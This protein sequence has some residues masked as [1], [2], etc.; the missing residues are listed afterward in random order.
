[1]GA[2]RTATRPVVVKAAKTARP[3]NPAVSIVIADDH[4]NYRK[5]LRQLLEPEGCKMLEA[6]DGKEALD[7]LN[8]MDAPVIGLIDWHMP[9]M[10][11]IEVCRQARPRRDAP[12]MFLILLTAR[13]A[14][15]DIVMGL[16]AGAND[17][18]TKPF[19]PEELVARIR[20]GI[21]LMRLQQTLF[22]RLQELEV[23]LARVKRLSGLLPICGYCKKIRDDRDY[24]LQV[25]EY[26][27]EHSEAHFTHSI[28][29]Q[30]YETRVKPELA[31][32]RGIEL[33]ERD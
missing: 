26:I 29:P 4:D 28:C 21:E 12:P 16:Q 24:W 2:M 10:D 17:Y 1:M 5:V 13:D 27:A 20:I 32:L 30:C 33:P 22:D 9:E 19:S 3:K 8:R 14:Q 31:Q 15:S 11:G 6:R 18:V 23:A 7:L 25:E